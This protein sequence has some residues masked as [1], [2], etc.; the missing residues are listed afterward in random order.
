MTA[1]VYSQFS[2][3]LVIVSAVRQHNL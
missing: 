2:T 3:N 1:G